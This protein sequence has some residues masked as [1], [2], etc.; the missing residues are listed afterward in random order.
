ML[1]GWNFVVVTPEMGEK[2]IDEVKGSCKMDK[3]YYYDSESKN[4]IS[5]PVDRI[6]DATGVVWVIKVPENCKLGASNGG[7]IPSVPN[8]P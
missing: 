3:S 8:L 1:R 2:S 5:F 6:K 4:W 7:N